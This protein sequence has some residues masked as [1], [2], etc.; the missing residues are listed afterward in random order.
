V[1][2]AD[3]DDAHDWIFS[4]CFS[5]SYYPAARCAVLG[6][7]ILETASGLPRILHKHLMWNA[8][9]TVRQFIY[10]AREARR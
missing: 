1:G 3:E 2:I 8:G 4:P 9:L 10:A 6:V 5:A 7:V